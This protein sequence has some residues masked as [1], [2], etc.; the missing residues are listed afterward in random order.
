MLLLSLTWGGERFAWSS[1]TVVGLLCGAAGLL[2][3]LALW[4]ARRGADALIPP[5]SLRRR[6]VA[7]GSV[8]MFL[9]GGATQVVPYFLP[10][11]RLLLLPHGEK[12][13]VCLPPTVQWFWTCRRWLLLLPFQ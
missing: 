7:V 6:S 4:I 3:V 2:G 1:P 5:A 13:V 10:F 12:G 9:Q 11:C 8:V